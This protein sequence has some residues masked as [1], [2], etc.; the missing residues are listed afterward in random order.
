MGSA[1]P[2]IAAD[3]L[4]RFRRMRDERV[5]F[6]TGTDEHGEKIAAAAEKRGLEPHKHCDEIVKSYRSLWSQLEIDFDSFVRTTD[7]RHARL[8]NAVLE[9]V[10]AKGD[11]YEAEYEGVYCV[12]CEEYKDIKELDE[13]NMCPIHRTVCD[14]R[15]E[16]NY[17]F[18]L[19]RYQREIEA[20]L[21]EDR[22]FVMP[23]ARRNEVL[24]WVRD[25]L[26]DFSIS[27][28]AVSWGIPI[29]RDPEQTV[30]VW[31]DALLGYVSALSQTDTDDANAG[32]MDDNAV[33]DACVQAGW[34][35]SIH[36][37]GK[38]ILRFHAVYWPAMLMSAD[39]PVP[40]CVFGHGFLT[41]DGLKMGKSLGNVLNPDELVESFGADAVRF[42]FLREMEFGKDGDFSETRFIDKVNASL[43]NDVGNLLNR[44][45]KMLQKNCGGVIPCDASGIERDHPLRKIAAAALADAENAYDA[46]SFHSACA[47]ALSVSGE[48]NKYLEETQPWTKLKKGNDEEKAMA[49]MD[50]TA[51]LEATRIVAHL[52]WPI[53]PSMSE[54]IFEQLGVGGAATPAWRD[55]S[56]GGL[57]AGHEI[58][59]DVAPVFMRLEGSEAAVVAP[60][61]CV[62]MY[63]RVCV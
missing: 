22:N 1:Y 42:Y 63:V 19:S 41:K 14:A 54:R 15:K 55:A 36:I 17:F 52:L 25:G 51:V 61:C 59:K 16:R 38:D 7:T 62:C 58:S 12:G 57:K 21:E 28:A 6:V 45:M 60:A 47:A 27:R 3:A 31:F 26:R 24:G 29:A 46:V 35:A 44:T 32:Q 49:Q 20:L 37:I 2:T 5:C 23:A 13:G 11:I 10:W 33:I 56:W 50:L 30:Y 9:R 18:R 39:L 34:P 4:A 53:V 43:A 48:C 8:V 40:S